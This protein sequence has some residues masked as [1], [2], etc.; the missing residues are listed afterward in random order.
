MGS[1]GALSETG[2][3]QAIA[4]LAQVPYE[5]ISIYVCIYTFKYVKLFSQSNVFLASTIY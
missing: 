3:G 4:E 2:F 5:Y 1:Q